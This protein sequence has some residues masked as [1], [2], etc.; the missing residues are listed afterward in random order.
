MN[1]NPYSYKYHGTNTF[2][3]KYSEESNLKEL[4]L[5]MEFLEDLLIIAFFSSLLF[6]LF[7]CVI[8]FLIYLTQNNNRDDKED[9][10][11]PFELGDRMKYYE[12]QSRKLE[13]VPNNRPFIV[14][15]DG[16]AFSNLTKK[17]KKVS[18]DNLDLPYSKEFKHAMLL[19]ANDLLHEFKCASVYTHS[20]EITLIF[21]NSNPE[22]QYI[23]DGKVYKLLSLIPSFA[24]GTFLLHFSQELMEN[25]VRFGNSEFDNND[26]CESNKRILQREKLTRKL[27]ETNRLDSVPTFDARIIVFPED[28][29]YE[30]V[31]HMI[32]RSKGDCTRNFISL[33]AE[34]YLGKKNIQNMSNAERLQK[35]KEKG[36]DLNAES[37]DF[38]LKHGTFLKYNS[39]NDEVEFYVFKNLF[40]V[41]DMYDFLTVKH[42]YELSK[43][44]EAKLDMI[45]YNNKNYNILFDF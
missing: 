33:Y 17:Y 32:W 38:S 11:I 12:E 6:S 19:T 28:K 26:S 36:Y 1:T 9:N 2:D 30:I 25:G 8:R 14:R 39:E 29:E 21:N 34:T 20:D 3:I 35:L 4:G 10:N 7:L 15:L 43:D 5:F 27:T 31:N 45:M 13:I 24:S 42:G 41:A 16:R 37:T 40:F 18:K 23:F 44:Q 22:S